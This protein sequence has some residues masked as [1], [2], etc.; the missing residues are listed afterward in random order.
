MDDEF[1]I[2]VFDFA[3]THIHDDAVLLLFIFDDLKLKATL[4]GYMATYNFSLF[5]E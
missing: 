3:D 4:Y 2:S 1:L 5:K